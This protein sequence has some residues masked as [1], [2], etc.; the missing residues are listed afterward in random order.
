MTRVFVAD[1]HAIVRDG[2]V[3]LIDAQ[4]DMTVAGQ[5][6]DTRGALDALRVGDFD[7]LILDL[8]LPG[9]GGLEV[10][11]QAG[12]LA[13]AVAVVVLS[14]H[15]EDR[16]GPRVLRAGAMAFLSKG[17]PTTLL[18]EAVRRARR[19]KRTVTDVVADRLLDPDVESV[20]QLSDREFQVL[21]L[22]ASGQ[23]TGGIASRLCVSPSTVSTHLA[24]IKKKLQLHTTADLV[25][26]AMRH[27][28][29]DEG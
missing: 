22:L 15:A 4:P 27:Q 18:L 7:V 6:S 2:L 25:G 24:H 28:L 23:T 3:R 20:D 12:S 19:G 1:D 16:F 13:P 11:S 5:A 8:S 21:R 17:R 14:M 29:V 9:G 26:F 10:L